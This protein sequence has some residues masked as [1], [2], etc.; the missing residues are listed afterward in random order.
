VAGV[1]TVSVDLPTGTVR[2][3]GTADPVAVRAAIAAAGFVVT[4]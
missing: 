4:D 1:Q 2:V 3:T